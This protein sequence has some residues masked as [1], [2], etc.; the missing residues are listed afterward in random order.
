MKTWIIILTA[1]YFVLRIIRILS[2]NYI[3]NN[4]DEAIKFYID[5]TSS[6]PGIICGMAYL[7]GMFTLTAD[8]I[9][10]IIFLMGKL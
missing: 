3:N 2:A 10:V 1:A 6:V 8:V 4:K 7:L 5:K 9:L